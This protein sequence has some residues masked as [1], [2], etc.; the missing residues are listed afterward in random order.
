MIRRADAADLPA[1]QAMA[2]R[3]LAETRYAELL[4]PDPTHLQATVAVFLERPDG[5]LLV[6]ED[7]GAVVGMIALVLYLH[8]FTGSRTVM[9]VVWW[10]EPEAR[11]AGVRLLRAAETW[12]R[13]QGAA[14]LQMV[15]P[16]DRVG[17]FYERLGYAKVE[18]SYQLA[19][20][21]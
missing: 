21:E 10:V 12:A 4:T 3:F 17:A 8:P 2:L 1:L 7:G 14:Y 6:S 19:L 13:E 9:E 20:G 15:A 11:G 18:T 5:V 16:T